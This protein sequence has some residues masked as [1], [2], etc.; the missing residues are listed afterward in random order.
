MFTLSLILDE[1]H[2]PNSE[3]SSILSVK[4]QIAMILYLFREYGKCKFFNNLGF[5]IICNSTFILFELLIG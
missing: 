4:N 3:N 5:L 2:S 1:L